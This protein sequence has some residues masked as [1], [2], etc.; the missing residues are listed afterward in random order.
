[1]LKLKPLCYSVPI[2]NKLI[3]FKLT[4]TQV[5]RFPLQTIPPSFEELSFTF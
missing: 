1:M 3:L 2:E 4:V 5:G